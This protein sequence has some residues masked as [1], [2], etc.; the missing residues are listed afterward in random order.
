[1]MRMG[2]IISSLFLLL[3]VF[4]T[5]AADHPRRHGALRPLPVSEWGSGA[6]V[7]R[8]AA[9]T[10]YS[11]ERRQLVILVAFKDNEFKAEAPAELWGNIFNTK[12][13]AEA[14]FVGSV[15]DYF[16]DQSYNQFD[17]KFDLHYVK[18]D[19]PYYDYHSTYAGDDSRS[20][21]LL[22]DL[23]EVMGSQITDWSVYDWDGD[24]YVDQ[25]LMLFPGKGQND[26]GPRD[27]SIWAHQGAISFFD[28]EPIKITQGDKTYKI[29]RY[30]IFPEL[31]GSGD[32]GSFGT[33]CHE[34]G[35]CLGLPD[36]YYGSST[37]VVYNWDIMDHG[38][39]NS[40]GYCPPSY[41]AH[42]R[43]VLGWLTP[44]ELTEPTTITNLKELN[45]S[46]QA[47]LIRND[48]YAN[49]YYIVENRQQEG[50]KWDASLPGSGLVVFHIDYDT[51]V[52]RE[53]VPNSATYKRYAIIPA[54][55]Y[56]SVTFSAHWAYPYISN[57]SL[58]NKSTPAATLLH[59]NTD[60]S[61]LMSKPITNMK[62]T[63]GIASFD[64]MGGSSGIHAMTVDGTLQILYDVG[65]VRIVRMPNGEIKKVM[66]R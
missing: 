27:A 30:G 48:A 63:D 35:H 19:K 20:G 14:P 37:S 23:T 61:K 33:L 41:S 44:T 65:P 57:N 56:E 36:F 4:V 7:L 10:I 22:I 64:F 34:Y 43:M 32:Y 6:P 40:G 51:K 52:W 49:E 55:D 12:D 8:R 15:H 53:E 60:G 3:L 21:Q 16:L 2:R 50:T 59:A 17:L 47:Y 26:G 5:A 31:S 13:F 24:F 18:L 66:K 39:Y 42:E 54:N 28:R 45:T 46:K 25:V 1:M 9:S 11:G 38:N 29:D 62:V 58:T